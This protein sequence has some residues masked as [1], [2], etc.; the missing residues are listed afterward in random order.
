MKNIKVTTGI[1]YIN[2]AKRNLIYN[3]TDLSGNQLV[4]LRPAVLKFKGSKQR[5]STFA[6]EQTIKV[7]MRS[8]FTLKMTKLS[9]VFSGLFKYWIGKAIVRAFIKQKMELLNFRFRI[10]RPHGLMRP[11]KQRRL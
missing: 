8:I 10:A 2:I 5:F 11:K 7:L 3:L 4:W 1:C 6:M 9:I